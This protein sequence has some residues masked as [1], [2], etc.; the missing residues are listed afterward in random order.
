MKRITISSAI[1]VSFFV[2][3]CIACNKNVLNTTPSNA[4][5]AS[6]AIKDIST[7][8][9]AVVGLYS[10]MT[11]TDYY[12]CSAV[13]IPELVGD[14]ET[15][16]VQN[17]GDYTSYDR[18]SVA[19]GDSYAQG[20]WQILYSVV[21][22]ANTIINKA[23]YVSVSAA[24][25]IEMRQLIGEAYAVRAL[26]YFDIARFFCFPYNY[27]TDS[28][29][30]TIGSFPGAVIVDSSYP[31]D[32]SKLYFPKRSTVAQ[33]YTHI[34][35]DID[36]SLLYLPSSGDVYNNRHP[37]A[38]LFKIRLNYFG[39]NALA[40]RVSLYMNDYPNAVRYANVVI[41]TNKYQ[42]Y[43][44]NTLV[45]EFHQQAGIESIFEVANNQFNNQG[46]NSVAYAYSQDGYGEFLGTWDLYNTMTT[47]DARIGFM[48]IGDRNSF[49]GETNVPLINKYNN[50]TSYLENIKVFRL[51]EMYLIRSEAELNIGGASAQAGLDDLQNIITSRNSTTVLPAIPTTATTLK[52]A[53]KAIL[54][55]RR[56]ELAFEGHRLFDLSRTKTNWT[57]YS[58]GGTVK[59][60]RVGTSTRNIMPIP[61][62]EIRSNP[63]MEQNPGY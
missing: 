10:L 60:N 12:G 40:A 9:A 27:S 52:T 57:K 53:I 54:L 63:L 46:T 6:D 42:L 44:T 32:N 38:S 8:R 61:L 26:A 47:Q 30:T 7:T 59:L 19:R 11:N 2:F 34:V 39:V 33:T 49:G 28:A 55:E 18:N 58:R 13:I 48:T 15:Q 50:I 62:S 41:A 23:K 36:S 21:I 20:T 4:I 31:S 45:D 56:K 43:H 37:D 5:N 35:N 3:F 24:D 1:Q 16:S 17:N 29:H 14:N 25:S 22:N 51:A